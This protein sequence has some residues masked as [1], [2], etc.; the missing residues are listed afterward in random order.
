VPVQ[1]AR[2]AGDY[3]DDR[4]VVLRDV[5]WLDDEKLPGKDVGKDQPL[6]SEL[7]I[8]EALKM[9]PGELPTTMLDWIV[10]ITAIRAKRDNI[11]VQTKPWPDP[12]PKDLSLTDPVDAR[13]LNTER[14]INEDRTIVLHEELDEWLKNVDEKPLWPEHDWATIQPMVGTIGLIELEPSAGPIVIFGAGGRGKTTFL[15][16][17]M[18]SLAATRTPDELHMYALDFGRM[19]LRTIKDLPHLG[20]AIDASE[21]TRV[22][23]LVRMLGNFVNE[24]QEI[25]EKFNSLED[26]NSKNPKNIFPEILIAIDNFA[27]FQDSYEYLLPEIMPLIR[28]GRAFGMHFVITAGTTRDLPGKLYNLIT[29]RLTLTQADNTAYSE[30]AGRGARNFDNFP[31][32]GLMALVVDDERVPVE[33]HI[34]MTSVSPLNSISAFLGNPMTSVIWTSSMVTRQSPSGW[35]ECGLLW[36]VL[37][38]R[39]NCPGLLISSKCTACSKSRITSAS[40]ICQSRTNGK[41]A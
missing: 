9:G 3:S 39:R 10:G 37:V 31:G 34:G 22:D 1:V 32:R 6:Y 35:S 36:V 40:G 25:L 12:L 33:F 15:K 11:P 20:A 17:L 23:Q 13:Y 5:I 4:T 38:P 7:E 2:T 27:E 24:R 14:E 26:Y 41:R 18:L 16:S 19:G 21:T 30:I 28:D 29:Q 8:A